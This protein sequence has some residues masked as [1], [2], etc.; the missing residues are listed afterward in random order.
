MPKITFNPSGNS[1]EVPE[2]HS[3]LDAAKLLSVDMAHEC[4]GFASC[5]TCRIVV[6][7]GYENLSGIEFEEEDM[8]DLA[9]LS[10]P[11]RLACQARI[12]G[13]VTVRIPG[14]TA[15]DS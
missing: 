5:S 14:E 1:G 15:K 10:P 2:K 8:M 11:Y 3:V 9:E 12:M 13:D 7:D 4:G 6:E